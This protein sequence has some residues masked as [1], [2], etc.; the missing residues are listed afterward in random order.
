MK[1][2]IDLFIEALLKEEEQSKDELDKL[3]KEKARGDKSRPEA[4]K[5]EEDNKKN[6]TKSAV[7]EDE[8]ALY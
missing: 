2:S 6:M 7:W 4:L 5:N 1:D 8:N 3:Q